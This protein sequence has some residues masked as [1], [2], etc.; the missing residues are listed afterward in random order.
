VKV[1]F[2]WV[3]MR[4]NQYWQRQKSNPK[5]STEKCQRQSKSRTKKI[6]KISRRLFT[7]NHLDSVWHKRYVRKSN[8][9]KHNKKVSLTPFEYIENLLKSF[10]LVEVRVLTPFWSIFFFFFLFLERFFSLS[11]TNKVGVIKESKKLKVCRFFTSCNLCL[12]LSML[13]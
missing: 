6:G 7:N 1:K 5:H 13:V 4:C 12:L 8:I 3:Q 11:L 9:E 2:L 10:K